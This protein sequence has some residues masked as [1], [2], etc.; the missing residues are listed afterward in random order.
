MTNVAVKPT[1][2][3]LDEVGARRMRTRI[4]HLA[5]AF[6]LWAQTRAPQPAAPRCRLR[7]RS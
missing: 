3:E 7:C 2:I 1:V 5:S 6:V 4:L